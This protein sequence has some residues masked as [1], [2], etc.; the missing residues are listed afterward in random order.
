VVIGGENYFRSADDRLMPAKKDQ[1][2]PDLSYFKP[3]HRP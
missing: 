2:P 3:A 1:A